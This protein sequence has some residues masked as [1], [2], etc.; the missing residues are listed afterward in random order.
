MKR[1]PAR[2]RWD[3]FSVISVCAALLIVAMIGSAVLAILI[4]GVPFLGAALASE[5]IRFALRMS[6]SAATISTLLCMGLSLL[7]AYA[8]TRTEMLFRRTAEVILEL[9]MCL[10]Y[11]VV[12][13]SL[14]I[15]FSTGFGK[16]LKELGFRVVFDRKGIVLAQLFV[17]LPFTLHM[18]RTALLQVDTRLEAIAGML[19]ASRWKQFL[20]IT[21]PLCKNALISAM[22]L[23]WSRGVGEFGATLML[24]GVTRMKTETLP[25]SIFLNISAGENGMAMAAAT[26]MLLVSCTALAVSNGLNRTPRYYRLNEDS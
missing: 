14:L 5:E 7:A 18:L 4:G 22:V 15:L 25:G 10:P 12:G 16:W 13:L 3:A 6:V 24:V 9:S 2:G 21:L 11:I 17:N 20:T 1:R 19:G 26:I 23:T 8:F